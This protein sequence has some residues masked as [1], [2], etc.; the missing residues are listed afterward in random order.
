MC[1]ILIDNLKVDVVKIVLAGCIDY[2]S[3][4]LRF[5]EGA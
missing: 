2:K 5:A 3:V 1:L 4:A